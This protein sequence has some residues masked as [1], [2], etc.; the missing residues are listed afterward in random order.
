MNHYDPIT[1]RVLAA[2]VAALPIAWVMAAPLTE[3]RART[4]DQITAL[5]TLARAGLIDD[6]GGL[7]GEELL[8]LE[9]RNAG[10]GVAY[11]EAV[12]VAL[13]NIAIELA[14]R[15]TSATTHAGTV[16]A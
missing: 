8:S 14:E 10:D 1:T 16:V 5:A 11:R 3:V 4:R 6:E 2:V 9:G 7:A 12:A 13:G 15:A